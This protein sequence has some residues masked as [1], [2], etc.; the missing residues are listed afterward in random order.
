MAALG[1]V[2]PILALWGP[3]AVFAAMIVWMYWRIAYVPGGQPIGALET[4]FAKISRIA[5]KL[6]ERKRL[7]DEPIAETTAEAP[8][9]A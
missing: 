8:H 1:R 9:A 6:F 7:P 4:G 3:F 5:R 2:D